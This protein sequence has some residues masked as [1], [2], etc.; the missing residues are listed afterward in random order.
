MKKQTDR[1]INVYIKKQ[2]D[3]FKLHREMKI[4]KQTEKFE[5]QREM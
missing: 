3:K 5:L 1:Q 4:K 2:S